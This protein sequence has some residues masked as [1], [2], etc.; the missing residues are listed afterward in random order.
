MTMKQWQITDEW[1][2]EG[3]KLRDAE[4][5]EPGPGEVLL[6]MKAVSLN[7]RDYLMVGR[8]YGRMSGE[9][10][11]VPL[12]DGVG[13]VV[14]LGAGVEDVALGS[15]RLPC[16]IQ[17]WFSGDMGP[18]GFAGALGG[19]LDG[20]AREY[21]PVPVAASV[22]VPEHLSDV[23]AAT[24]CCAAITA[25]NALAEM[26]ATA[27]GGGTVVTQGTGGV[28]LFALQLAKD[29]GARVISTSSSAEKLARLKAMGADET[30][31]Y[32]EV[33]DWGKAVLGLTDGLGAD[34]VVEVGGADTI[35]QSMRAT[36]ADGTIS[37]V[38]NV[39]GSVAE[40]NLPLIFMFRKRLAGISTGSVADFH[41]MMA[42]IG[43]TGFRPALD[44]HIY[45][46]DGLSQA[47]QALPKGR[48]FG[49]IAVRVS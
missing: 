25:W 49:K 12:S 35:S 47:L 9:L 4:R 29:R 6:Q 23:E 15:R 45:E 3:L 37:L 7:Y 36:R 11:L 30:I 10:P 5:P 41:A 39:G 13:E 14:A 17:T 48:H 16:F 38:G 44:D 20:T 24:L 46:F 18:A 43:E 28:S 26:P 40:V 31:N 1:S 32:R 2:F 22:P 8:G 21:M 34:L 42:H 33:P 19:P 27:A